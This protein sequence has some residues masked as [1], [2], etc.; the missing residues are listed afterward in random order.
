[1]ESLTELFG[2]LW[3]L[4]EGNGGSS[5]SSPVMAS[6]DSSRSEPALIAPLA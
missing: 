4:S 6:D 5:A 2:S 3:K 1:L